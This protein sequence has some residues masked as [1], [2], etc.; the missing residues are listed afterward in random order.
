MKT[1][2]QF[3]KEINVSHTR[4]YKKIS[5]I[6]KLHKKDIIRKNNKIYLTDNGQAI[7]KGLLANVERV[8]RISE[9]TLNDSINSFNDHSTHNENPLDYNHLY[10]ERLLND[11]QRL[12]EDKQYLQNKI[13][14]LFKQNNTL[15]ELNRNNQVLLKQEQDK[16]NLL[17]TDE[18]KEILSTDTGESKDNNNEEQDKP[19]AQG[20]ILQKASFWK[21]L[22]KR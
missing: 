21:R 6:E 17:T 3:S 8:E 12:E 20:E 4:L 19:I 14:E 18:S 5:E 7:L 22:F 13:D 16:N 10:I 9:K 2:Y 11:I 1:A 15:I